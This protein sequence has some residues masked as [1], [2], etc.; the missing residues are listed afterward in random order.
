MFFVKKLIYLKFFLVG[1]ITLISELFFIFLFHGMLHYD[2]LLSTS[3]AFIISFFI[4]FYFHKF[5]T[6]KDKNGARRQL[7]KYVFVAFINLIINGKSV[8]FLVNYLN[9]FYLLAQT[10]SVIFIGIESFIIY[11]FIIFKK[12]NK[13]EIQ[14]K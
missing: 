4:N 1:A 2:L 9:V 10:I 14:S 3:L 5:W 13:N 6:F 8:H 11:N 7:I 12:N